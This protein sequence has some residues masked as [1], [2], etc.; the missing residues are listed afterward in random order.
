MAASLGEEFDGLVLIGLRLYPFFNLAG[1]F[2]N[3]LW[4]KFLAIGFCWILLD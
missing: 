3:S 2:T 4:V 1:T